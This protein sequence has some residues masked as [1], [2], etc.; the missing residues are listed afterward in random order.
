MLILDSIKFSTNRVNSYFEII[1]SLLEESKA[2]GFEGA[3]ISAL[4]IYLD[5]YA[6]TVELNMIQN[7]KY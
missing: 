7:N 4:E 2:I 5:T 3:W 6:S 1:K